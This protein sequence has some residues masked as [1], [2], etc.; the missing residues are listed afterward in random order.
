MLTKLNKMPMHLVKTIRTYISLSNLAEAK[1]CE[2]LSS[3]F[4]W[5]V[6][7]CKDISYVGRRE[8]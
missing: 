6:K 8:S 4:G 1:N 2:G 7:G 3:V 5:T